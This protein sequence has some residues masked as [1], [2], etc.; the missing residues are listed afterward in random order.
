MIFPNQVSG[1]FITKRDVNATPT[2]VKMGLYTGTY[3]INFIGIDGGDKI[4]VT[5]QAHA[6]DNGDKAPGKALTYATKSAILKVLCLESGDDEESREEIKEKSK[7]L[8]QEQIKEL[9]Q[10][11]YTQD[12]NGNPQWSA[13]GQKLCGAYKINDLSQLLATNFQDAIK[14]CEKAAENGN[15]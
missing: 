10:Y 9:S 12:E 1:E 5:V 6:Q 4:T 3:E 14:R 8:S 2:P 11:C 15:N 7:T 13:L